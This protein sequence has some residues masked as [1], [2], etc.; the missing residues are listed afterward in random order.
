ME[1]PA[2]T[3]ETLQA[4]VAELRARLDEAEDTLAAI[5]SG[6]VDA[7][8]VGQ[9]I[10]TLDS[11]NAATNML[12]KDVLAQ[13]ED[14]VIAFDVDDHVIFM[15]PAAE[16]QYTRS[17]SQAL[18]RPRSDLYQEVW[19]DNVEKIHPRRDLAR[20]RAHRWQSI[21]VA[22]EGQALHVE[23]TLSR[24]QDANGEPIGSL[25]VIRDISARIQAEETLRAATQALALRERQFSTLVEN[26]PDILSRFDRGL[27]HLYVSPAIAG[28]VDVRPEDFIGRTHAEVGMPAAL[29]ESWRSALESVFATGE[30]C[31]TKFTLIA[32]D[33]VDRTFSARLVPEYAVDGSIESVLSIAVDVTEQE[34]VDAA[35]RESQ[36]RLEDA[37]RRKDEFLATLAHELRNPLAPIRN[38]VQIMRL[39]DDVAMQHNA[40]GIIERQL[41]QMVHLVDDLLDVGRITQ[42]KVELRRES[43]D[44]TAIIQSA[45]ETSRP[46]IDT[47]RHQLTVRLAPLRSMIVDADV[48]RLSQIVANLLNNAAKYTPEGGRIEVAAERD[49]D[50]ALITVRDSGVGIPA[51]MLPR[52]FDMFA[53]VDRT[54]DR[55]QGGLG[56]GLALVKSL[57]ELHGGSVE[58][59]SAGAGA[60]CTFS[61]RLP[62]VASGQEDQPSA[63]LPV[64]DPDFGV[65]VRVLVVDDNV[66]HAD[67]LS[68]FLL[69]LGYR[70]RIANDGLEAVR[71]ADAFLP[72]VALLD[73]GLPGISGTE[74]ARAIRTRPWGREVLLIALSGWGQDEDRRRSAEAGFNHHFVKPVDIDALT[75]LLAPLNH[76]VGSVS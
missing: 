52:V 76:P 26:S 68:Q 36:R 18:G 12:R 69:M 17:S 57:V 61:V 7:L 31:R 40:R 42:G 11:A 32:K 1:S 10:Y 20:V 13:M 29:V 58:A 45:I 9:D 43:A 6:D 53:Q 3:V 2:V 74:V 41:R 23:S 72:H 25:V 71:V 37:D 39:S 59:Q 66:D 51:E 50:D 30:V 73:I 64:S 60:G 22:A 8:V 27:R 14:A 34:A 70:T 65:D 38:A 33:G 55:A 56:I 19:P 21:H 35:L 47:G 49:G 54:L 62:L 67:S 16:R 5:R 15:N 44:V 48:T 28:V 4:E 46:V 63:A 75:E 24:L